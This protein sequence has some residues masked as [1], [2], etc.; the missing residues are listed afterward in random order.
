MRTYKSPYALYPVASLISFLLFSSF[1]TWLLLHSFLTVHGK[2]T[3]A[4]ITGSLTFWGGKKVILVKL[5][6]AICFELNCAS[7]PISYVPQN[8]T[9]FRDR[10]FEEI[11]KVKMRLLGWAIIQY[12]W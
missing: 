1:L 3:H 5:S 11:I 12:E 9:I 4:P 2:A 7:P 6:L 8:A 10:I